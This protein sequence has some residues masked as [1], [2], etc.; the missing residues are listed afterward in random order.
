[1]KAFGEDN[2]NLMSGKN[3]KNAEEEDMVIDRE[4]KGGA[5]VAE[6]GSGCRGGS[7]G[8]A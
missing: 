4:R 7:G 5:T 1:M 2:N 6:N 3:M 8:D